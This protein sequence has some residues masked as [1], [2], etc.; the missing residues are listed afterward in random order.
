MRFKA[1]REN[2]STASL[3]KLIARAISELNSFQLA[4]EQKV[5]NICKCLL[6]FNKMVE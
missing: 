5:A 2:F 3:T 4:P 1:Q 6:M